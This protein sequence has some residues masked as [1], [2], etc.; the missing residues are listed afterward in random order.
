MPKRHYTIYCDESSK[1]GRYFSNFYGSA[2]IQSAERQA[3]EKVL[4]E[5]KKN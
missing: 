1:K 2:S 3:I 4:R 5:K